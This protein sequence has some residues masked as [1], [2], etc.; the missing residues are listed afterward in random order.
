MT[1]INKKLRQNNKF[2][3]KSKEINLKIIFNKQ[4]SLKIFS[5]NKHFQKKKIYKK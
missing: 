1:K 3:K 2:N 4:I 5:F